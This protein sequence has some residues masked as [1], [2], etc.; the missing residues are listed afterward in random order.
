MG[1]GFAKRK[2]QARIMQEQFTKIQSSLEETEVVGESGGGLVTLSLNGKHELKLLK[3]KKECV[4]PEDVE[5][6]EDLLRAAYKNAV[7]Q[8]NAKE[9]ESMPNLSS[10][11]A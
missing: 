9:Q 4:D 11:F 5:G 7:D 3:I 2:K 1:T 6:L 8:L 10:F